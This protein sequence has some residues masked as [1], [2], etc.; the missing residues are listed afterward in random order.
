M[1]RAFRAGNRL[2]RTQPVV[3]WSI[4]AITV[5]IFLLD[6]VSGGGVNGW[7]TYY[8]VFTPWVPWTMLTAV[9]AHASIIHLAVNMLSL[10]VL[11]PML[12][13]MVGRI[14]F[15]ALYLVAG[16]GGSVAVLW[17]APQGGV[18]GASGA[19]FGLLGALFVI[20]RGLGGNS[21]QLVLVIA[22]NLAIGFFVSNISWQAHLGGLVAGALVAWVFMR[23][24]K[25]QQ[26]TLQ[27]I[28]VAG[29]A[30]LLVLLT[31]VRLVLA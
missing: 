30:V 6:L 4:I 28:L 15:V 16:F 11:G 1:A 26:R 19:I 10:W 25:R 21:S 8:P 20:Q 24:R 14:R 7:L 9:L 22:L 5:A 12:E 18:L 27:V 29:V 31:A 2:S 23:T 3:T 17:L 13:H